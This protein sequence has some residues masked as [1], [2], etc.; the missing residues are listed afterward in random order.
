MLP[1]VEPALVQRRII[2]YSQ[3]RRLSIGRNNHTNR[4]REED[5]RSSNSFNL[6][7]QM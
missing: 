5:K 6:S 7:G 1:A 2:K 3:H 4:L